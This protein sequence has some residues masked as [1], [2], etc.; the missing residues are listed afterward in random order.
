MTIS[1]YIFEGTWWNHRE[2]PQI[3][4]FFLALQNSGNRI[5]LSHRTFRNADDIGFWISK[6][7]KDEKAFVYFAC[8]GENLK[9]IPTDS[10]KA[11]NNDE[12]LKAIANN[13]KSGAIEFLHFSCCEMISKENK[14]LTL[15]NY[16]N[17]SKA[18]WVSGY[19]ESVDWLES[20]L[21]DL[22][23]IAKLALPYNNDSNKISP[24]LS[25]RA[26][27]FSLN[28]EQLIRSLKFSGAYKNGKGEVELFPKKHS[29]IK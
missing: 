22:T 18:K 24:K 13:A 21:L 9:L 5:N 6:I 3:L 10:N 2:T 29:N 19:S 1:C 8:H 26:K 15:K 16:L 14:R 7:K 23:L 4:P 12:L 20:T 25:I 27:N 11:I 28:Y 17:A